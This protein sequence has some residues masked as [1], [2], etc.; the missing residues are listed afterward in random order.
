MVILVS[1]RAI[2]AV[3]EGMFLLTDIRAIL[4]ETAPLHDLDEEQR[5]RLGSLLDEI[6]RQVQVIR[7][8]LLG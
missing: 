1:K 2:D 6:G 4:R 5:Q 8:E 3:F 7:E